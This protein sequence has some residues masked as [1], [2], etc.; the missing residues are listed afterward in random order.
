MRLVFGI[1]VN[2]LEERVMKKVIYVVV[3]CGLSAAGL[4]A[5]EPALVTHSQFQAVKE[6]G[7]SAYNL[8]SRVA[9]EGIVLNNSADLLDPTPDDTITTAYNVGAQWQIYFQGEGED[10]AGTAVYMAQLYNNLPWIGLGGG[11]TN[12]QFIAE[13]TRLNAAQF[14]PGDRVRITGYY[15]SYK[16]KNNVNEQHN[17]NPDHDFTIELLAKA[18]LHAPDLVPLAQL[19][20]DQDQFLFD[21][22]RLSGCEYFQGRLVKIQ[23]VR[24]TDPN[25]WGPNAVLTVTDGSLTFPVKLG[26]GTG[27]YAGSYNLTEPFD[28]IGIMDQESTDLKAGYRLWVPNYDGNGRVLASLEHRLAD[29]VKDTTP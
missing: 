1:Q 2:L 16:G 22:T 7:E 5:D 6:T 10:H 17:N 13:L 15:L 26:R 8:S 14:C 4:W 29:Q 23:G 9:L 24:F 12:A 27:I 20:G 19:K 3:L 18:S 25:L 21:P 28:V 11:Y